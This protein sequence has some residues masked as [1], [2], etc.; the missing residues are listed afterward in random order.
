MCRLVAKQPQCFNGLTDVDG[1]Q[2]L[3]SSIEAGLLHLHVHMVAATGRKQ[4]LG[5]V[6]VFFLLNLIC[7]RFRAEGNFQL[8]WGKFLLH[9]TILLASFD[10]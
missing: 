6:V 8:W 5:V 9:G 10:E 3:C 1:R 4:I 7:T 2:L